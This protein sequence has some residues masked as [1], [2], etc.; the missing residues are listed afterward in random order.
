MQGTQ[1]SFLNDSA[2][3]QRRA[4]P[5]SGHFAL[6]STLNTIGSSLSVTAADVN[7]D[8]RPDLIYGNSQ[9]NALTVLTN[10]GSGGFVA[11][12]SYTAGNM[13]IYVTAADVNGDGK[14]DLIEANQGDNTLT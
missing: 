14:V 7:G 11:S 5:G 9:G 8:G 1:V 12:G 2:L 13:P 4:N 6:A 3:A 10:D